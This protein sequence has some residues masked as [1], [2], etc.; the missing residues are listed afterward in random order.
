MGC[1]YI[2]LLGECGAA[3][4]E[5]A[6][7]IAWQL[8]AMGLQRRLSCGP[9]TVFTSP[10]APTFQIPGGGMV[11][12]HVFLPNGTLIRDPEAASPALGAS[13]SAA[14]LSTHCWGEY[15]LVRPSPGTASRLRITRDPS[16]G[17]ACVYCVTDGTGFVTSDISIAT[18]L[19]LYRRRIDWDSV[20]HFL[21][22]TYV[23]SERTTLADVRELLPGCSLVVHDPG[24]S[25]VRDWSPWDFVAPANRHTNIEDAATAVRTVVEQTVKAWARVDGS[26]L[27][28]LSGGLDSSIVATC[29]RDTPARVHCVTLLPELPGADERFYARAVADGLGVALRVEGLAVDSARFDAPVPAWCVTPGIGP[30]Q[31]AVDAI[32]E[33]VAARDGVDCFYSGGGGDTVFGFLSGAAPAADAFQ[34]R[35]FRTG[36][37]T[38]AELAQLH[39]CSFWLAAKLALLKLAK[40]DRRHKRPNGD[41]LGPSVAPESPDLHPWLEGPGDALTGD[42]ERI[43]GLAGTQLFRDAVP[44]GVLHWLR[45]P[46]LCQPIM[47]T[48]LSIPSWMWIEG[49]RNRAVARL[50]F[51]DSLPA[52]VLHRRSKGNF[53]QYNGAVYR[54]NK[55]AMRKFLLDGMLASRDLLDTQAVSDLLDRPLVLRDRSYARIVD[56]CR[57]ENWLRH[58]S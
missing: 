53:S 56:L 5:D 25:I 48:C 58:Q 8:R 26:A 3:A 11:I 55:D 6:S 15:L 45:L 42:R 20:A 21:A 43:E 44:R 37:R 34:E 50:A 19:G 7:V 38:I 18:G 32:M 52:N 40:P 31:H 54:R 24:T 41:L 22:Y 30:L 14:W 29:L 47:E 23:K 17:V 51:S 35:G 27:V 33:S 46:L 10:G 28:E 57:T 2:I 9:V 39:Q 12:G 49:G 16:G 36:I 1:R 4:K 13:N